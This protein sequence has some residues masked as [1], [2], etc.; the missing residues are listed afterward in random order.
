MLV[1][2]SYMRLSFFG[3]IFGKKYYQKRIAAL[4]LKN[5]NRTKKTILELEGLFVKVGQLLSILSNFLPEAFQ[6]PLEALQNKIPP[7]PF[8]E[9]KSR[10]EKELGNNINTFFS[11]FEKTPLASASIGQ[12][13]R[14]TLQDGTSV[15]VKVQHSNIEKIA[16]IDLKIME[17]LTSLLA[18]FYKIKG[19]EFAY[20]QVKK[21]IQEE[22][23][24]EK[25]AAAMQ[26]IQKNLSKEL[27]LIIP[28]VHSE[29]STQRVL[30][31]TFCEG[32]KINE[33][34]T[35]KAWNINPKDL[36]NRLIH[37][38][39]QMIFV[40]GFYHAD[41]HPGNILVQKDGTIVLLDFG[42]TGTLRSE[43]RDGFLKLIEAAAK[44]D[45]EKIIDALQR[46]GFIAYDRNAEKIA[47]KVI[48]AF[49][50]F[51]QNEVEFDGLNFK[52]L[53][54]NPFQTSLFNLTSE[55][56]MQGIANTIQVPKEYVLLNR[57]VTLLL[58]ICNTLDSSINPIEVVQPYFQ[59]FMLG[60]SGD[61]VKFVTD[62]I[63]KS[64]TTLLT[65]PTDLGEVLN[66]ARR[67][68]L[69][70]QVTSEVEKTKLFYALG[71]QLIF[72]ILMIAAAGGS[73]L[74]SQ[75]TQ[76]DWAK[77]SGF[78]ALFFAFLFFRAWRKGQK[79]LNN[80]HSV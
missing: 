75:N 22:L 58:G 68:K 54:V 8:K 27:G 62:F 69:E 76:T 39:C 5:A 17:R 61:L 53:K 26:L 41:P 66:K 46:L 3:K 16:A 71:Q 28:D 77:W 45:S 34:A 60:E 18:Y 49:R 63:K 15:V 4:H 23:N 30:T 57:M 31:T 70:I 12:V 14:A 37:A 43:M 2:M 51:L 73:Y 65:I 42:A 44:N 7:R 47:E 33:T 79:I 50:N 48:L 64:A 19:I 35:L 59:K 55:I 25:E 13:H 52:D 56:G 32:V 80:L 40:D 74:F 78:G 67:G 72:A 10:I 29:F 9:I 36:G 20:T 24:F 21:M 6:E 11:D 38:Y 1:M